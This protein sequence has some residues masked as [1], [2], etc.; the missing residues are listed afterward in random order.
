VE[1][2]QCSIKVQQFVNWMLAQLV[3]AAMPALRRVRVAAAMLA[4]ILVATPDVVLVAAA[5]LV[6]T[7][8]VVL[9]AAAILAA[10]L[11]AVL[12]AILA[13]TPDVALLDAVPAPAI[14]A[15][16]V[17]PVAPGPAAVVEVAVMPAGHA[18]WTSSTHV[19]QDLILVQHPHHRNNSS[20]TSPSR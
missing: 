18:S 6:A 2:Q 17:E 1:L 13:A 19:M 15:G 12:A 5:I 20:G 10:T 8:D 11:A 14:T 4:A 16:V 3:Q 9:V 7:P